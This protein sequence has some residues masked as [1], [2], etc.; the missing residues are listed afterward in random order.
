M[1]KT[2]SFILFTFLIVMG[3]AHEFWL[4]PERF[5]VQPGQQV[6]LRFRVGEH[7]EGENWTGNRQLVDTLKVYFDGFDDDLEDLIS[8]STGDSLNL[9]FFNEGTVLVAFQS[10]NK[11][12]ELPAE[13]FNEYL[14]EDGIDNV[15]HWRKEHGENDSVSREHYQRNVKTLIQVGDSRTDNYR[16]A[17]LLPLDII[18]LNHPYRLKKGQHLQLRVLFNKEP[19]S[20]QLI[21]VWHKLN[22][23]VETIDLRTDA[24]GELSVPVS[25]AGQWMASTVKMERAA[26]ADSTAQWQSYW[27]SLTWGY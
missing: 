1:R 7:F 9:Q 27:G 5:H 24:K 23:K 8:D 16:T 13:K 26:P 6:N 3:G 21:K 2:F 19:L 14:K 25:L 12:I 18:P 17:T 15:A 22:G 20:G 10:K 11:Y 4:E